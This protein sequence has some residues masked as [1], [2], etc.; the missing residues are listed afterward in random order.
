[1]WNLKEEY[2]Y[3]MKCG[4]QFAIMLSFWNAIFRGIFIV[5]YM[6]IQ[7]GYSYAWI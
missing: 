3:D 5:F 6:S 7:G 1:M 2:I 4:K